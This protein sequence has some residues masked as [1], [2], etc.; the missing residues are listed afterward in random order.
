MIYLNHDI[1]SNFCSA[2]KAGDTDLSNSIL[3]NEISD[4]IVYDTKKFVQVLSKSGINA[5]MAMTDEALVDLFMKNISINKNLANALAFQIADAN[6]IINTGKPTGETKRN[7][8]K[9]VDVLAHGIS[10]IGNNCLS[11]ERECKEFKKQIMTQ[12]ETKATAKGNYKRVIY[13]KRGNKSL[14]IVGGLILVGI[15]G[16]FLYKKY[17]KDGNLESGGDIAEPQIGPDAPSL[18]ASPVEP[19]QNPVATPIEVQSVQAQGV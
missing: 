6:R 17:G 7:W 13:N 5:K 18:E 12:I 1:Y 16:Y 4:F 8:L 10:Q 19:I 3:V 9:K 11:S 15:A 2:M 14:L